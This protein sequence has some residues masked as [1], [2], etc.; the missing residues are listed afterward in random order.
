M[1]V[2]E[3]LRERCLTASD[4]QS[5]SR[6]IAKDKGVPDYY[7]AHSTLADIENGSIPGI[8]KLFSLSVCLRLP[9]DDLLIVWGV[10]PK[11]ALS[12]WEHDSDTP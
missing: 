11:E 4:V 8:R 12:Y 7:V 3:L 10:D 1:T 5:I 6:R 9:Y 2:N